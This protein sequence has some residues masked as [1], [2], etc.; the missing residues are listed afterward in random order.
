M[1]GCPSAIS[2]T[3]AKTRVE[4]PLITLSKISKGLRCSSFA[5]IGI[6]WASFLPLKQT[7]QLL[8]GLTMYDVRQLSLTYFSPG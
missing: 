5:L 1:L 6:D 8:T 2:Q 4:K 7:L 3:C